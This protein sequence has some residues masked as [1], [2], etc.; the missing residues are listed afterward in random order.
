M[1]KPNIDIVW[2]KRDLRLYDHAAFQAAASSGRPIIIVYCFEPSLINHPDYSDRH[3]RF[4]WESLEC[5]QRRLPGNILVTHQEALQL[6]R[7]LS[8]SYTLNTVYSHQEVGVRMTFDRDVKIGKWF[9]ANSVKWIEFPFSGIRRGLSNRKGW[10]KHWKQYIE[11]NISSFN[12][13]QLNLMQ[14]PNSIQA[15]LTG[16]PIPQRFKTRAQSFQP[17]GAQ[18]GWAYLRSFFQEERIQGYSKLISKPAASRRACSRISPYLAWG[19]L[20]LRQVYQYSLQQQHLVK[21]SRN[22]Q[23]FLSRLRW[24]DHFIQKFESECRIEFENFNPAFNTLRTAI[25]EDKVNAWKEGNT[26]FPLVDA[27]MRCVAATGYLNFRMRAM[28]V[29]FLTHTLWQPWQAGAHHLAQQFLD[30]EPGIHYPQF[31]M[32]ASTTGIH[33]IRVYNPVF[34]SRKHDP[35][36]DFIRKW[37]PEIAI[38]PDE[39]IHAPWEAPPLELQFIGFELGEDYPYPI[40]DLKTAMR[41]A[42]DQLWSTQKS[43]R[44]KQEGAQ[45]MARHVIPD[46]RRNQ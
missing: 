46:D 32:Q 38:L 13:A 4:V 44:S 5:I 1:E 11:A 39:Y 28:L 45:I 14:I 6:F 31:Q 33:T 27:S 18:N 35:Y 42:S 15:R 41:F 21:N 17:G 10:R 8:V 20:S 24:R 37:V 29:S 9:K 36:G 3:W 23:N 2:L 26:G 34:N 16:A 19:N 40:V 7:E 25:D 43:S 12:P 30:Y 22:L